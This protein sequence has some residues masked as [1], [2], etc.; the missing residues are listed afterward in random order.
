MDPG[1]IRTR[2]ELAEYYQINEKTL[3]KWFKR[4]NIT[5]PKGLITPKLLKTIIKKFGAPL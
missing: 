3:S 2:K 1:R 4:E 5:L